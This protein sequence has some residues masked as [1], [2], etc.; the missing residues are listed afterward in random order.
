MKSS[1]IVAVVLLAC[2]S[3]AA[4]GDTELYLGLNEYRHVK[5]G[6]EDQRCGAD[7]W[8]D[9]NYFRNDDARHLF[10]PNADTLTIKLKGAYF[11]YAPETTWN[12][13][14]KQIVQ[15]GIFADITVK[16]GSMSAPGTAGIPGR[17][18]FFSENHQSRQRRIPDVNTNVYGPVLYTGG[19]LALKFSILEFD[20][21]RGDKLTDSLLKNIAD[22]GTQA[23]A[24]VPPYLQG[25]LTSLFQAALAGAKS[26]DDLF[27]QITF[28]LDDRN[29]ADN[30]P[31][32]PLRTGDIVFVRQSERSTPVPWKTLCYKPSTGE[33]FHDDLGAREAKDGKDGKDGRDGRDGRDGKD[34]KD[35]RDGRDAEHKQ[36]RGRTPVA[37]EL[38]L[39]AAVGHPAA[40]ASAQKW[41][42]PPSTS[43]MPPTL[44]YVTISLVK[45]AGADV[46]RIQDAL[47]YERFVSELS[48]RNT[49]MGLIA[50]A[51]EV[52]S[53]FV[54]RA[55]ERELYRQI[56][57]LAMEKGSVSDMEI[58]DAVA[59]LSKV[60]YSS[61]LEARGFKADTLKTDPYCAY[62]V[63]ERV[64]P[65]LL[66]RLL[67][68]LL[69]VNK[70]HTREKI[71]SM[72]SPSPT[73]CVDANVGLKVI[74]D[75]LMTPVK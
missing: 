72:F 21:S 38:K 6:L 35:G 75:Q 73:T 36:E 53:A 10:M 27:G 68:K 65:Q 58:Y 60:L 47:T 1:I 17:L 67:A 7:A 19:G 28:V 69:R 22:L 8:E 34:G 33:V 32:S 70:F 50:S 23:S 39:A 12:G 63:N 16:G 4:G 30:M 24:G 31:T 14:Q 25:P 43:E 62:L 48:Q 40:P 49:D 44:N 41:T 18:V 15:V 20:Q 42:T 3:R 66:P 29:G 45:N 52:T 5:A 46:G 56:D 74:Q 54:K 11:H 51:D 57:V 71:E 9:G 2:S 64:S 26:K 59:R 55:T 61:G 37:A 13:F